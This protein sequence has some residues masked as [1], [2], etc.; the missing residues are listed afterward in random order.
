MRENL[1]GLISTDFTELKQFEEYINSRENCFVGW[2]D[3]FN[4]DLGTINV[5][6][7]IQNK[8]ITQ[9]NS[10]QYQNK[11]FLINCWVVANTLN[12]NPQ[13]GDKCLVMVLDEKSNNFFKAQYDNSLPLQQ[14]TNVNTSKAR[15]STSN[16]VA[17]II[18]PNFVNGGSGD[19]KWG[20]IGGDI[21]NQTDLYKWLTDLQKDISDI[22]GDYVTL[23]TEQTIP[24][25]KQFL[26]EPITRQ[27]SG[28]RGYRVH[29]IGYALGDKPTASMGLGR[30]ITTDKNGDFISYLQTI[31]NTD[32]KTT[33]QLLNRTK[34]DSGTFFTTYLN[35]ISEKTG[36]SRIES[37]C[38]FIPTNSDRYS[39]GN[40]THKWNNLY[41][42]GNLSDGTNNIKISDIQD[43]N[44]NIISAYGTCSTASATSA[45]VVT[46]AD[47]SWQLKV[48]TIIGVKFT[49]SN[50]ASNVTLNVNNTGAKSIWYNN[51]KYTGNNVNMCGQA[52]RLIYYMYDGTYWVWLNNSNNANTDTI[53]AI[54]WTAAGT[55]AKTA[56]YTSYQ[57]LSKSYFNIVMVN[58][59]TA[60]SKLTLNVNGRGAKPIYINESASSSSNYTLPAGSYL[61]YYDGSNYYFHTNGRLVGGITTTSIGSLMG[62]TTF[63]ND[64]RLLNVNDI[65][66]W[67]GRYQTNGNASNLKYA[68]TPSANSNTNEI[69]TTAWVNTTISNAITEAG[70]IVKISSDVNIWELTDGIYYIEKNVKAYYK[71]SSSIYDP[72]GFAILKVNR[73]T[74]SDVTKINFIFTWSGN[75]N[76]ETS[77]YGTA[78]ETSGN[79]VFYNNITSDG[80]EAPTPSQDD[81]NT[82]RATTIGW[83]N[84]K[85]TP[86]AV[87]ASGTAV[88]G[89]NDTVTEYWVA[90][91]GKT[92]YRI[93]ASGWKECGLILTGGTWG[94]KTVGL[95]LT[96]S[97]T[98]YICVVTPILNNSN[99]GT[100]KT[101]ETSVTSKT[102]TAI[103]LWWDNTISK[104]VY[105][106]GY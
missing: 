78:D 106:C 30:F 41:L 28:F 34:S 29:N 55:A 70:S 54:S 39:L 87:S 50:S 81:T 31:V 9:D 66:Y 88:T 71:S 57:L 46:I 79:I 86:T 10:I 90:S 91:N 104:Q 1:N 64:G 38:P 83:V 12:R 11:P 15:K 26:Q 7:A 32:G 6:P 45:K 33:T 68:K 20:D 102:T 73:I 51:A 98:N 4:N 61:V 82:N 48:G 89:Q 42:A 47:A 105:C 74:D 17:V 24:G 99:T 67:D 95:G 19:V 72:W 56:S 84:T 76:G 22:Q 40:T 69:A 37:N 8:L 44:D 96:F 101:R 5:Q 36:S 43:K 63:A 2:V 85:F 52:N 97:D 3:S 58:S 13:K 93:W 77:F 23:D 100:Y 59:N 75:T 49:N 92:W 94:N 16:C 103:T 14:Q 65:A 62:K 35:L 27:S 80:I 60:K 25:L 53:P 21:K 18:N